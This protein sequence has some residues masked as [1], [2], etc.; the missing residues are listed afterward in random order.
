[1]I[2]RSPTEN[3]NGRSPGIDCHP[4][5]YESDGFRNGCD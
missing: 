5:Y 2:L 1:M 3:E 4:D